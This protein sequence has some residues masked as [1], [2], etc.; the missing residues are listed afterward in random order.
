MRS[1]SSSPSTRP[2]I[3]SASSD[4]STL[5]STSSSSTIRSRTARTLST[6]SV[7]R[8]PSPSAMC[9][10]PGP[11]GTGSGMCCSRV[12]VYSGVAR[13]DGTEWEDSPARRRRGFVALKP[14]SGTKRAGH[15]ARLFAFA[16][17]WMRLLGGAAHAGLGAAKQALR[18]VLR[19][20]EP[21]LEVLPRRLNL[22]LRATA[23]PSHGA[24]RLIALALGDPLRA[25][26]RGGPT[27]LDL[28]EVRRRA[29]LQ[30]LRLAARLGLTPQR[31]QGL[32]DLLAAAHRCADC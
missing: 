20:V 27:A 6:G 11:Y 31:L 9:V 28:A 10:R 18:A 22:S 1:P 7:A 2:T 3:S 4:T 8:A 13:S 30:S 21:A 12:R 29:P 25:L 16:S 15:M 14:A 19:A 5:A 26:A 24:K 17:L 23:V 32:R